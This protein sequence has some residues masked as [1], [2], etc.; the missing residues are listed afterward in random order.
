MFILFPRLDISTRPAADPSAIFS[1]HRYLLTCPRNDIL[2]HSP[3]NIFPCALTLPFALLSLLRTTASYISYIRSS[4]SA[5]PSPAFLPSP[6][7]VPT[8][9]VLARAHGSLSFASR[10]R[11][12]IMHVCRDSMLRRMGHSLFHL[13]PPWCYPGALECFESISHSRL[14]YITVSCFCEFP[15]FFVT[16][17]RSEGAKCVYFINI[18]TLK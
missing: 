13:N 6:Q 16:A 3:F 9:D 4:D 14:N 10:K 12:A 5:L 2:A 15:D 8:F 7:L 1:Q 17:R 18:T 11:A